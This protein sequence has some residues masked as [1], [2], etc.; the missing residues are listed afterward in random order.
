MIDR[1]ACRVYCGRV[2]HGVRRLQRSDA[3]DRIDAQRA[4][5]EG[6]ASAWRTFRS[7]RLLQCCV[8]LICLDR[9]VDGIVVRLR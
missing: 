5:H 9:I 3:H 1:L 6:T 8:G 7:S 4:L 2:L